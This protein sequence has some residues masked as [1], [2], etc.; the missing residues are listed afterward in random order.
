MV[1][2]VDDGV[3]LATRDKVWKLIDAHGTDLKAIHPKVKE[4]KHL[5]HEADGDV[6]EQ[7]TDMGGQIIKATLKASPRPPNQL[8]LEFLD[9]PMTGKMVNTY[10]DVPGGTKVVTEADMKSPFM[11]EE[12]LKGAILQQLNENFE[13]DK[14]YLSRMK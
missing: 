10:T 8:I 7:H 4:V 6:F 3:Y 5:R 14:R 9:G 12:Q 2:V 13:D 11:N 1:K